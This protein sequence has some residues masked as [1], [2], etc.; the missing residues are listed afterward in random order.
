MAPF[1][2]RNSSGT[3]CLITPFKDA[4]IS[5]VNL[6]TEKRHALPRSDWLDEEWTHM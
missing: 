5:H 2:H 4:L 1:V 3:R 6:F